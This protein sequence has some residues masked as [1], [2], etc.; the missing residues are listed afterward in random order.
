MVV[1]AWIGVPLKFDWIAL[2]PAA[3]ARSPKLLP[4]PSTAAPS[5]MPDREPS[6]AVPPWVPAEVLPAR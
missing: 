5:A 4:V 6:A 2:Q 3:D 1:P